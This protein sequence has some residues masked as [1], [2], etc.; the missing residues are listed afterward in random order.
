MFRL[1]VFRALVGACMLALLS[2][3]AALLAD[4]TG[5][6]LV[7][8]LQERLSSSGQK[9]QGGLAQDAR[10]TQS[11][12]GMLD[13]VSRIKEAA[14]PGLYELRTASGQI[15][16]A[17]EDGQHL[18]FGSL[19]EAQPG[20]VVN[21]TEAGQNEVR[22]DVM[23]EYGEKGVIRYPAEGEQKA[24]IAVF[25]D[26][27]C[28]YCRKFH[29]EVPR[30]N[31]LGITVN[32]FGF[33]RSGPNTKSFFKYESVWC[34]DDQQAAMDKAKA[35]KQ[36]PEKSCENPVGEQMRLGQQVEVRG[37]PAIVLESGQMIPGYV[38]ADALA[39]SLGLL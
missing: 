38:P 29:E 21:I 25:T 24:E 19:L 26:I 9:G 15:F 18:I 6:E 30:M 23:A 10:L 20:N 1:P 11:V 31:E 16:Y 35:G 5:E 3:P 22:A 8:K 27:D 39:E 32:Y 7:K 13:D 17:S 12:R 14:V 4:E 37:T 34:S 36:V 2:S 33:P 28:P